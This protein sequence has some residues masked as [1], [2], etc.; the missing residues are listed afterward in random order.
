MGVGVVYSVF[1]LIR[2]L[3]RS[4][5]KRAAYLLQTSHVFLLLRRMSSYQ[6]KIPPGA[7]WPHRQPPADVI[8]EVQ[9][10]QLHAGS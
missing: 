9:I 7:D 1:V 10:N 2:S 3:H 6:H 5:S 8:G 4:M